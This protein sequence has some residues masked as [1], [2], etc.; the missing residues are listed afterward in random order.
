MNPGKMRN[1]VIFYSPTKVADGYGGFTSSSNSEVAT[2]FA[3]AV[4]KSG[5]IETKDGKR[6]YYREIELTLRRDAFGTG[7]AIGKKFTVDGAGYYRVNNY[8]HILNNDEYTK[9]IGTLEP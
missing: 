2:F 9:I 7:S 1:K 3:H 5:K 4:E 8:Y 6:N